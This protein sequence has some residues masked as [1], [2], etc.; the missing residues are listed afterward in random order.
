MENEE[1][2]YETEERLMDE[3]DDVQD[4]VDINESV[5]NDIPKEERT[6]VGH[7]EEDSD[8]YNDG[9]GVTDN[10]VSDNN[11]NTAE[12][13]DYT[14]DELE[15]ETDGEA[16]REEVEGESQ[17]KSQAVPGEE[18]IEGNTQIDPSE[19]ETVTT[20][21]EEQEDELNVA[22]LLEKQ[23][24]ARKNLETRAADIQT[25]SEFVDED[26]NIIPARGQGKIDVEMLDIEEEVRQAG[27]IREDSHDVYVLE[28]SIRKY[29]LFTPIHVIPFGE[30]YILMD[31]YRRLQA[32]I[33]LGKTRIPAIVDTTVPP[34]LAKYF[35]AEI[36]NVLKY[37]FVEKLNY[38]KFVEK[39]QPHVGANAIEQSLGLKTGEYLKMQ[40]IDQFKDDFPEIFQQ[41]QNERLSIEQAYKK[42]DKEIEKQQKEQDALN[43]GEM[44]EELKD[45]DE[46]AD[47][48]QE[49]QKQKLGDRK[50]LDPVIRRSVESRAGGSCECC[51]YG[52]GE[53]DLMGAFQ[54][55][56]I[57]PVQ[58][59]GSDSKANLI[60]LCHNCHKL[61]HDYESARFT[62]EQETYT[63]LNEVKRIVVL[64]NMLLHM[65]RKAIH[66][67]RTNHANIGRQMDKGVVTVGQA[68]QKAEIDLKG[69]EF[70]NNSP[71]STYVEA[72]DNLKFGGEVTGELG[73]VETIIEDEDET[74][75]PEGKDEKEEGTE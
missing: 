60:L 13:S 39:T 65:R 61:V 74:E 57:I 68:L 37:S 4:E 50:I 72:T 73:N 5:M 71:Y 7:S 64:G 21:E 1:K 45:T 25:V 3:V 19:E 32:Y 12:F 53:P 29:G 49:V 42:M 35:Q 67:I 46:L 56:H 55:H 10:T 66:V 9:R 36:N 34:E 33:G 30:Y 41:V 54:V 24:A 40:Y 70:F 58:Y 11:D 15:A 59:G 2:T 44:D 38:G 52:Q 51:G 28:D 26:G 14:T 23:D 69:E 31:G 27:R 6:L 16:V 62:P 8:E 47:L 22:D 43:S 20:T 17:R 48:Q 63:R 18:E 75:T